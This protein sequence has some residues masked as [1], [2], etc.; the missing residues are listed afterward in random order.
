M[1]P[2]AY[3]L[4]ITEADWL[5]QIHADPNSPSPTIGQPQVHIPKN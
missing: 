3:S 5:V 1:P 4:Q 2:H